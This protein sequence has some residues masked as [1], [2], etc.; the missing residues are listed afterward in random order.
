MVKS[1]T[2]INLYMVF[3]LSYKHI[4]CKLTTKS[5]LRSSPQEML[6]VNLAILIEIF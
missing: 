2:G 5:C 4:Y 3:C 1:K 6:T